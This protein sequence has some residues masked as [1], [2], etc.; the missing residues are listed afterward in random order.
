MWYSFIIVNKNY[1]NFNKLILRNMSG[2]NTMS[3]NENLD[4]LDIMGDAAKDIGR[5]YDN[6]NWGWGILVDGIELLKG[7]IS[8][9][10]IDWDYYREYPWM[11]PEDYKSEAQKRWINVWSSVVKSYKKPAVVEYSAVVENEAVAKNEVVVPK[12]IV[13]EKN[14]KIDTSHYTDN[15]PYQTDNV[16]IKKS[17]PKEKSPYFIEEGEPNPFANDHTDVW[18]SMSGLY[19]RPSKKVELED[20]QAKEEVN[21]NESRISELRLEIEDLQNQ[22]SWIKEEIDSQSPSWG[23]I[24]IDI[25]GYHY[26]SGPIWTPLE[27]EH[28]EL[29]Y[30]INSISEEIKK[31]AKKS[32]S[33]VKT[34]VPKIDYP[35]SLAK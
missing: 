17:I 14:I 25:N 30:Q 4:T 16:E 12:P 20:D 22:A 1:L 6:L 33:E 10:S 24:G 9:M 34:E 29:L 31:L 35:K 18:D 27:E 11:L 32:N 7:E 28:N 19:S 2:L 15:F 23:K 13:V 8:G 5:M 21:D 3:H 26:R